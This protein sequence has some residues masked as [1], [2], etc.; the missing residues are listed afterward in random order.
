MTF[1]TS[2]TLKFDLAARNYEVSDTKNVT[3]KATV[4]DANGD[5]YSTGI[6]GDL[7]SN[8]TLDMSG[9]GADTASEKTLIFGTSTAA[10]KYTIE[11]TATYDGKANVI[12]TVPFEVLPKQATETAPTFTGTVTGGTTKVKEI[13]TSMFSPV[14]S[15]YT[16]TS[17]V[18]KVDGVELVSGADLL[19]VIQSGSTV[20]ADVTVTAAENYSFDD[21]MNTHVFKDVSITVS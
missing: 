15:S 12:A 5:V 6:T 10:G 21:G 17:L 16:I 3:V 1:G 19:Y 14:D 11:I 18:V 13:T 20:M 8:V 4:K 7:T 2:E 9:D